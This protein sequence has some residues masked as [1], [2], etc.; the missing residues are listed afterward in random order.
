MRGWKTG[1]TLLLLSALPTSAM[2]QP[3]DSPE[4]VDN[5]QVPYSLLIPLLQPYPFAWGT[6]Q[7][8]VGSDMPDLPFDLPVPDASSLQWSS[9]TSAQDAT[10]QMAQE[11]SEA[12]IDTVRYITLMFEIE[13]TITHLEADYIEQLQAAGWSRW[14]R[15]LPPEFESELDDEESSNEFSLENA[16]FC[17]QGNNAELF[18]DVFQPN[19]NTTNLSAVLTIGE[20]GS[21]CDPESGSPF[22][23]FPRLELSHP[24]GAQIESLAGNSSSD[25]SE[26][27]LN[28]QTNLSIEALINHYAD[29]M[30]QQG[31]MLQ[32]SYGDN[33]LQ[34]S[35]WLRS[36][37]SALPQQAS[38]YLLTTDIPN[39][40]SGIFRSE[41]D[42]WLTR[43]RYPLTLDN[44]AGELPKTTTIEILR[45]RW[46]VADGEPL[47]LWLD[48]LPPNLSSEFQL[49]PEAVVL[50]GVS[51]GSRE[52]GILETALPAQ[53]FRNGY[54]AELAA[55][56]WQVPDIWQLTTIGRV[57][58]TSITFI[59][60]LFCQ[61]DSVDQ[62]TLFTR[63][64]QDNS[65]TVYLGH[66]TGTEESSPCLVDPEVEEDLLESSPVADLPIP[67]LQVPP[68]T[69]VL[70]GTGRSSS[71]GNFSSDSYI[72][73][74]LAI[75]DLATHYTNQLQQAGWRQ[76]TVIQ[77][78]DSSVSVWQFETETGATWQGLLSLIAHP[79]PGQWRGYFS[80]FTDSHSPWGDIPEQRTFFEFR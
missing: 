33:R 42:A 43:L 69:T 21:L 12:Q 45:D 41:R 3:S 77:A 54:R 75:A 46:R 39:L 1:V 70:A 18:L 7:L 56:G 9:I 16:T 79:E 38:I 62:I 48:Q 65:T 34:W 10:L 73:S 20:S 2:A 49:P 50:G 30:A 44:Q 53:T 19:S 72:Y 29:E 51:Y 22:E 14:S 25:H 74:Q 64:G 80:A 37:Y 23:P 60:D 36:T 66:Q 4:I 11:S 13:G 17:Q 26:S 15:E 61:S 68:E 67:E 78:E 59:P 52:T 58:E 40:Y 32:T 31:W 47:E 24:A 27:T 8:Q 6:V 63:P 28:I 55:A 76:Q 5:Q 57:F 35:T 71:G